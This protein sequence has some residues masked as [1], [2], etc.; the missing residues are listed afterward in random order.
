MDRP[1]DHGL[2]GSPTQAEIGM[3]GQTETGNQIADASVL[4]IK[5]RD[6][7]SPTASGMRS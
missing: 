5:D 7:L 3:K 4:E 6:D 2:R 1:G